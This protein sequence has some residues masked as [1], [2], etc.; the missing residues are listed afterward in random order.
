MAALPADLIFE[1]L[2]IA[3]NFGAILAGKTHPV[4]ALLGNPAVALLN[5]GPPAAD[6]SRLATRD[7]I[8]MDAW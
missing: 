5:D 4:L 2:S 6:L 8:L 1:G 7:S 3:V